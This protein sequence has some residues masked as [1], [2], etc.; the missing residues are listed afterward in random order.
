M[1]STLQQ[2]GNAGETMA[3]WYLEGC[4]YRILERNYRTPLGEIDIV[5]RDRNVIVFIEVKTR[6]GSD[7]G[8]PKAAVTPR[9]QET[10]SKVA[11]AYL[12]ATGQMDARARFDVVSILISDGPP[13]IELVRN[14]FDLAYV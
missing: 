14:A 10:L 6:R 11:L 5:A 2:V 3:A 9:K 1:M 4:G 13:G 7:F 8:N 12:K